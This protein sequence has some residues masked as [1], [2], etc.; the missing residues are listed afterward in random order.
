MCRGTR[1]GSD[2]PLPLRKKDGRGRPLQHQYAHLSN[3]TLL[4]RRGG[5]Q[6]TQF[7]DGK[8]V[9][10]S[11]PGRGI[12]GQT[13][14]PPPDLKNMQRCDPTTNTNNIYAYYLSTPNNH[15]TTTTQKQQPSTGTQLC[16]CRTAVGNILKT[17]VGHH[18]RCRL[19]RGPAM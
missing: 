12:C 2:I 18:Q 3:T 15:A 13:T 17:G 7:R 8:H 5:R 14:C 19:P 10:W 6:S 9:P 16:T 11:P 4:A 1:E